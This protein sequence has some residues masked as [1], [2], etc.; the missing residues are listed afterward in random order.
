M[1]IHTQQFHEGIPYT[2][3]CGVDNTIGLFINIYDP[4]AKDSNPGSPDNPWAWDTKFNFW[5]KKMPQVIY[6]I[7]INFQ[8]QTKD[9]CPEWADMN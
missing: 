5:Q 6:D 1:V 8:Q 9:I 3:E 7:I 2:L 4:T